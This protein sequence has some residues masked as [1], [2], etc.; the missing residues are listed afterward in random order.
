MRRHVKMREALTGVPVRPPCPGVGRLVPY[1]DVKGGRSACP[2]CGH[3]GQ[4][5]DMDD[6]DPSV[7][8]YAEDHYAKEQGR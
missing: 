3:E 8:T 7:F 1:Y 5:G 2:V 4:V 6:R